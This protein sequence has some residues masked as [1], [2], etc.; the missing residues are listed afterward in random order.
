MRRPALLA[1]AILL[2]AFTTPAVAQQAASTGLGTGASAQTGA[3]T[4]VVLVRHAE[5]APVPGDDPP[6]STAGTARAAALAES[7]RDAGVTAVLVTPRR[8]TAETAAPAAAVRG[9]TPT[10]IPFGQSTAEHARLVTDAVRRQPAGSVVLV[11][12]HSNTI[13]AIVGALGGPRLPALCDASY[14]TLFTVRLAAA[15][16]GASAAPVVLRTRYGAADPAGADSCPG[17]QAR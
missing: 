17:M 16:D 2:A 5:K 6:L 3:G 13:P 9:L 10:V 7:L 12:G 4:L 14:A 8:R 1:A 15:A 11:V